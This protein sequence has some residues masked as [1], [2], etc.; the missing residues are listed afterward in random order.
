MAAKVLMEVKGLRSLQRGLKA[1]GD[2]SQ[3]EMRKA[4]RAALAPIVADARGKFVALG[5]TGPR[6][7]RTVKG[8]ITQTGIG[9]QMGGKGGKAQG[10]ELG[11]EFGAR[12]HLTTYQLRA[13]SGVVTARRVFDY[14]KP[15]VFDKWTGNQWVNF[16]GRAVSGRAFTPA[17]QR[18]SDRV[19]QQIDTVLSHYA[20]RVL[21]G[22]D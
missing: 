8:T 16:E 6:T 4:L 10:Y 21:G 20:D 22:T 1:L 14:G 3:Q 7:S 2:G 17:V 9:V 19:G 5:G 11:R 13:P 15:T 12:V 18:G